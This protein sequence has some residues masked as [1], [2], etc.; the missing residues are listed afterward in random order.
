MIFKR[1][2]F[3]DMYVHLHIWSE[4]LSSAVIVLQ[5]RWCQPEFTKFDSEHMVLISSCDTVLKFCF[6]NEED[7][8][9][10]IFGGFCDCIW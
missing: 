5:E 7:V 10:R 2:C 3:R 1:T 6:I 8:A 4:R 9:D